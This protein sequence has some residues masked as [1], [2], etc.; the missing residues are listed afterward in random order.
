CL[1]GDCPRRIVE[2]EMHL[3]HDRVGLEHHLVSGRGVEDCCVVDQPEGARVTR[4]RAK[5]LADQPVLAG[6]ARCSWP[7]HDTQPDAWPNSAARRLRA[8]ASSTALTMPVSS[9][10]RKAWATLT[11]SDT[12][13]RA[14]TSGRFSSS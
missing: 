8:R 3:A 7:G 2:K 5:E 12:T 6:F 11:Y 4:E 10:S 13:T 14:G 1:A 9:P